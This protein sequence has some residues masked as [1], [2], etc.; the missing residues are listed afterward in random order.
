M[1]YRV[2]RSFDRLSSAN[3]E[4]WYG[5]LLWR[6]IESDGEEGAEDEAEERAEGEDTQLYAVVEYDYSHRGVY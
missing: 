2:A 5:N 6:V 1:N 3:D 4:Q